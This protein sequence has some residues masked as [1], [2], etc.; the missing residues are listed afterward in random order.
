MLEI[1]IKQKIAKKQIL[2]RAANETDEEMTP[3]LKRTKND[4][5]S[6]KNN[7]LSI[8][9]DISKTQEILDVS[10]NSNDI[11]I[12]SNTEKISYEDFCIQ[13]MIQN[14]QNSDKDRVIEFAEKYEK[15]NL[16]KQTKDLE[17]CRLI[18]CFDAKEYRNEGGYNIK[19]NLIKC[20]KPLKNRKQTLINA[21][22][23]LN[24][25]KEE[26][27][28]C[29]SKKNTEELIEVLMYNICKRMPIV[30]EE[31]ANIYCDKI[32][33]KPNVRCYICKL[34]K[35][36]CQEQSLKFVYEDTKLLNNMKGVMWMCFD[37][38]EFIKDSKLVEKIRNQ[39]VLETTEKKKNIRNREPNTQK[40]K[41]SIKHPEAEQRKHS[42]SEDKK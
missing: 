23:F 11:S 25:N 16:I 9:E 4:G 29:M 22:I 14:F 31:C 18:E 13:Q 36:E 35:H 2:E 5:N 30:C 38:R 6:P 33:N 17:I 8:D 1:I 41:K 34:G 37:C 12:N 24:Q 15:E 21:I 42:E 26:V 10:I 40:S 20:L 39:I 3:V 7:H 28:C 32:S 27:E 19:E